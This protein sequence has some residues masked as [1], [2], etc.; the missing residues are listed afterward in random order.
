M[1]GDTLTPRGSSWEL[2]AAA[3]S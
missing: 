2:T 3:T 1:D